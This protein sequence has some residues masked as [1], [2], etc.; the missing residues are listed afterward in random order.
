MWIV[1]AQE[2]GMYL[3]PLYPPLLH[4]RGEL[5]LFLQIPKMVPLGL[6]LGMLE[7]GEALFLLKGETHGDSA[8]R[9]IDSLGVLGAQ[10]VVVRCLGYLREHGVGE[11]GSGVIQAVSAIQVGE[12]EMA[13]AVTAAA[14][15]AALATLLPPHL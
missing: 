8:N 13:Q 3:L 11:L 9:T 2:L 12:M 5:R 1:E 7:L 10:E 6:R 4:L 15:V 14:V